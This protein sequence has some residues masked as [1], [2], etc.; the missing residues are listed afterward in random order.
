MREAEAAGMSKIEGEHAEAL[1]LDGAQFV[2]D[3]RSRFVTTDTAFA[4]FM[5][6]WPKM[7]EH[8]KASVERG[9]IEDPVRPGEL[10]VMTGMVQIMRY[11]AHLARE[12]T[13][14]HWDR[15]QSGLARPAET[16]QGN[17]AK[18]LDRAREGVTV[19]VTYEIEESSK[20]AQ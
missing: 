8:Y 7:V 17:G 13:N 2:H 6:H 12:L 14:L 4:A 11:E 16:W 20:S 15:L 10:K 19:E 5:R 9:V 3:L 1:W 18:L